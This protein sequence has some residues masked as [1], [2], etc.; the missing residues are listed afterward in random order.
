MRLRRPRSNPKRRLRVRNRVQR[1]DAPRRQIRQ[2]RQ[3]RRPQPKRIAFR[4]IRPPN[5]RWR[6]RAARSTLPRPRARSAYLQ[7]GNAGPWR[8]AIGGDAAVSSAP[9]DLMPNAETWL[10]FTD[11][12]FIDPAGTGYS[13]F[14]AT[15]EDVRK[16]F[17]SIDERDRADDPPL[18]RKV[19]PFAVSQ[20]RRRRELW[21][22]PRAEDR[23]RIADRAGRRGEGSHPGLSGNGFP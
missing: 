13:R 21:R 16:R 19:R 18:A 15:G 22:H 7:F 2:L 3:L 14:V 17:F 9:P 6:C 4:R 5:K 1:A 8:L 10:D 20:I 12:V 23:S 11:L